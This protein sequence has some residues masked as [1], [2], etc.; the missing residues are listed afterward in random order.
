[1]EIDKVLKK[2]IHINSQPSVV[3]DALTNPE[4][5]KDWLFGTKVS[6][7]WSVG[8]SIFFT[9]S[10]EGSEYADKGTILK[11]E[12]NEIF[13]YDYWSSFS[14]LSDSPEN[15]SIITFELKPLNNTTVLTLTQS[16]FTSE[17]AFEHSNKNWDL[18]LDLLKKIAE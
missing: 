18:T 17:T 11:F 15:Y 14:G 10:W 1:M 4:L 12:V 3:W 2:S 13:Q 5:I 6:S 7:A 8:S 9:G 16:N